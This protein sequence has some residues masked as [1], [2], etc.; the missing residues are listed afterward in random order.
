MASKLEDKEIERGAAQFL[1]VIKCVRE[2]D[3]QDM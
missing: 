2:W 1:F 3:G